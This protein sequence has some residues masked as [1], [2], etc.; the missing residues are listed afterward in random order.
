MW[1]LER[2]LRVEMSVRTLFAILLI[3]C[4]AVAARPVDGCFVPVKVAQCECCPEAGGAVGGH[5][6]QAKGGASELP[7]SVPA[8]LELKKSL[9]PVLLLVAILPQRSTRAVLAVDRQ[10]PQMTSGL[11]LFARICVR[12]I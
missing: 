11:P 7:Q 8:G 9:S 1:I 5:C 12:L 3:V 4:V 2:N 10:V 6:C